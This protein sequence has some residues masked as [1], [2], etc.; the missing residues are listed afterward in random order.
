MRSR[1][2]FHDSRPVHSR[3]VGLGIGLAI[4]LALLLILSNL[5][6]EFIATAFDDRGDHLWAILW[7]VLTGAAVYLACIVAQA[8]ALIAA[9]PAITLLGLSA[10]LMFNLG[11]PD[12]YP[13][14]L[15]DVVLSSYNLHLPVIVGVLGTA[16]LWSLRTHEA[17]R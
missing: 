1:P 13:S 12:W 15:K 9:V 5:G 8:N 10:P 3:W 4:S 6:S 7:L 14:W 17:Q 11:F 16:S 2:R